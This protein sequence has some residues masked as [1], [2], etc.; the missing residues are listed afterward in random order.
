MQPELVEDAGHVPFDGSHRDDEFLGDAGIGAALGDQ[1]HH[2]PFPARQGVKR[3]RRSLAAH[4]A[5]DHVGVEHRPALGDAAHRVGEHPEVSH[6]FLQQVAD[7]LRAF[8]DQGERI[9]VLQEL[10]Q[11]QHAHARMGSTDRQCR[12]QPVI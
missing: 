3:P 2:L 11:D 12:P 6:L 4:Q 7:A 9:R 8:G 5:R 1:R 10:G